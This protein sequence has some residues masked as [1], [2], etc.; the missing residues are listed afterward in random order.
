MITG[1]AWKNVWRNKIRSAVVIAAFTLGIFG[2]IFSMA[3]MFGMADTRIENA[4]GIE[5]SHI[6]I[7]DPGWLENNELKYTIPDARVLADSILAL[8]QVEAV[9]PRIKIQGMASTSGNATGVMIN[10]VDAGR[11][12]KLSGIDESIVPSGGSYIATDDKKSIIIGKK[13]A[14]TLKLAYYELNE[15]DLQALHDNRRMRRAAARLD[16]LKGTRFR[17]EAQFDET[18]RETLGKS[19]FDKY[20]FGIRQ[21]AIKYRLRKKIVLSFQS[22]DGHIAY[23]AFRVKGIYKTSNSAFDGTNVF[24]LNSEIA[25]VAALDTGRVN[26]IAVR[27]FD[28]S[29]DEETAAIISKMVP[30]LTVQTWKEILPEARIY[31]EMMNFYLVIFMVIILLAL[32]F[33]IVNTMLMAVL[34]R[35]KELGMLMAIGMNKARL[36]FMIMLETVFLGMTGAVMGMIIS[37]GVILYTGQKGIDLSR[38]YQEGFN[39]MG[40]NSVLY[41]TMS[42]ESFAQVILMVILTGIIASIYPARKAIRLNPADAIRIDM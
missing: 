42:L 20:S 31:S 33:G 22:L 14:K 32:G 21:Q 2:G 24:V 10:G 27:L 26:E 23:D 29:S 12:M 15:N 7:H 37:Y 4:I 6:Q 13:L 19:G 38:M 8:P 34:E 17:D 39:A 30:S 36:F 1:I 5:T 41:P 40:L 11:E 18:L 25:P 28:S 3:V 35:I 9:S 16:S